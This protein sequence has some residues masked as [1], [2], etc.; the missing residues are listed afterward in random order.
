MVILMTPT[1]PYQPA[2]AFDATMVLRSN[3][4]RSSRQMR[5]QAR[6]ESIKDNNANMQDLAVP[7]IT[8]EPPTPQA[9]IQSFSTMP[10]GFC[11]R[12]RSLRSALTITSGPKSLPGPSEPTPLLQIDTAATNGNLNSNAEHFSASGL[13]AGE[14][15]SGA[16]S[17]S[18]SHTCASDSDFSSSQFGSSS[19]S[20]GPV[21]ASGVPRSQKKS[22][23]R[24]RPAGHVKRPRNAFI[25]FRSHVIQ[26]G[27][28][29]KDLKDQKAL[30]NVISHLWHNLS[31]DERAQWQENAAAEKAEHLRLHPSYKY[32]PETSRK[33]SEKRQRPRSRTSESRVESVADQILKALGREGVREGAV[34]EGRSEPRRIRK[35]K[36]DAELRK[37]HHIKGSPSP[38]VGAETE[39]QLS[40]AS[41]GI[42]LRGYRR[43]SSVPINI[44]FGSQN[45]SLQGTL[46]PKEAALQP[47]LLHGGTADGASLT[48]S[49]FSNTLIPEW[50][51]RAALNEQSP[52]NFPPGPSPA[53][54]F[55]FQRMPFAMTSMPA[56]QPSVLEHSRPRTAG[57]QLEAY[58]LGLPTMPDIL[59]SPRSNS[60]GDIAVPPTA[61]NAAARFLPPEA[62]GFA[63]MGALPS[64]DGSLPFGS[65]PFHYGDELM[66][67]PTLT[68][69]RVS[70][71]LTEAA[72]SA[73]QH[74]HGQCGSSTG[75]LPTAS[76]LNETMQPPLTLE[77]EKEALLRKWRASL[78][79]GA[80]GSHDGLPPPPFMEDPMTES[81]SSSGP[82]S[83][84]SVD[85][86]SDFRTVDMETLQEAF[87]LNLRNSFV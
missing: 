33:I 48:N 26:Q 57:G 65:A 15:E 75:T 78:S 5:Q 24:K 3:I 82:L 38:S 20:V 50:T 40:P 27:I 85:A 39:N 41:A 47:V 13:D 70:S 11:D 56:P 36:L 31:G 42:P 51:N 9:H 68:K 6:G 23:A 49:A 58:P 84:Y 79:A 43:S 44:D 34:E 87:E 46:K 55:N 45:P 63:R 66:S 83:F 29:P 7:H 16:W 18:A 37:T 12:R 17:P 25:L 71:F 52:S 80:G 59:I 76:G 35:E 28:L 73:I 1:N 81:S 86:P 61:M 22:H 54:F 14:S 53:S 10:I 21:G 19:S 67:A 72:I 69:R 64:G 32:Q 2:G 62:G 74:A 60:F 8:C 4:R 77:Q 30:S